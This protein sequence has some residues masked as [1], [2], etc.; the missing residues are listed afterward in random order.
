[1][2]YRIA[3]WSSALLCALLLV[4]CAGPV[5]KINLAPNAMTDIKTITIVRPPEPK[6]YTVANFGHGGMA[7]GLIGGL[8]AAADQNS[9][10]EQLAKTYKENGVSV[11]SELSQKISERL[12]SLG[13][14]ARVEDAP[15]EEV[16]GKQVL[17]FKKINSDADAVLVV[18]PTIIGFVATGLAGGHNNDYLPTIASVV[19]VLGKDR[20]TPIYRGYHVTGWQLKAEGWQY[21][22][23]TTTFPN[24]DALYSNPKVSSISLM[25]AAAKI[26][27]SIAMDLKQQRGIAKVSLGTASN[28]GT[29]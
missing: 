21:T 15:W 3:K 2:I 26:A 11:C 16:D 12:N 13:F 1:M 8:V 28:E 9:K 6:I 24:F 22:P 25:D 29:K 27:N 5:P 4:A 18:S 20:E 14:N 19:T 7:F 23:P 17:P 10:Q